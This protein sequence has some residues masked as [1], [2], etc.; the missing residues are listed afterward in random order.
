MYVSGP[1]TLLSLGPCCGL[2][3][4]KLLCPG[5]RIITS[6]FM[7]YPPGDAFVPGPRNIRREW[8]G[9]GRAHTEM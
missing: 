4:Y 6:A 1:E 9:R 8:R 5:K 7:I 2:G 3:V